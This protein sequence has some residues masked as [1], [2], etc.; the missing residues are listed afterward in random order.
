[1]ST[2]KLATRLIVDGEAKPHIKNAV[3]LPI[4]Q[5]STYVYP[6]LFGEKVD[7]DDFKYIRLNNSPNHE[8]LHKKLASIESTESAL[9]T[10]SGMAAITATLLTFLK[11]GDHLLAQDCLYGGTLTFIQEELSA[12]NISVD[13][14]KI[15]EIATLSKR[16][17]SNTRLI[18]I[19]SAANPLLQVINVPEVVE[20]ARQ[21]KLLTIIDNTFPSP[22][23]YRPAELGVDLVVHS[24]TKYLNGHSDIV[25]GV[26]AGSMANVRKVTHKLNHLGGSLD[27]HACFLLHRSLKTLNLRMQAHNANGLAI[28]QFLESHPK[29]EKVFYPG[30]ESH[31]AHPYARKHF[32]GFGGMIS[33]TLKGG[34]EAAKKFVQSTEIF[35]HAPSLGGVESLVTIPWITTHVGMSESERS[36]IGLSP[37]LLRLSVGIEDSADLISDLAQAL[38]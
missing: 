1:M 17:K 19:E 27:P 38:G 7:Y 33:L 24:A 5:S 13:F 22:I 37:G 14:F 9:V 10:A 31:P 20:I 26:V 35:L 8:A 16:V 18:Y 32:S 3:T 29:V 12:L 21:H 15:D 6:D 34:F 2:K 25:A 36:R 23:N 30:L 28:A 4:F 11:A